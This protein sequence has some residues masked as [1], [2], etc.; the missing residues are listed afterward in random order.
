M[1][2]ARSLQ[3]TTSLP[4]PRASL[5][6]WCSAL[7]AIALCAASARAQVA[8]APPP[9]PAAPT[10]PVSGSGGR[11]RT[12]V[13]VGSAETPYRITGRVINPLTRSPVARAEVTASPMGARR[14]G[15]FAGRAGGQAASA[16]TDGTGRFAVEVPSAGGWSLNVSAHGY[17]SQA[18]DEHE[19]FSTAIILTEASP[20]HEVTFSLTPA[21]S[22]EGYVMD[23]AGEAVRDAQLTLSVVPAAS[24]EEQHPRPQTR[25]SQRTDDRGYFKFFGLLAGRYFVRV[26]AQPWYATNAGRF[27]FGGGIGVVAGG[28]SGVGSGFRSVGAIGGANGPSPDPLDVVYPVV[29]YPGVT[30]YS[31]AV[32]IALRGGET[33]EADF[34]LSPMPGFHLHLAA[35][36]AAG[37]PDADGRP[38]G[39]SGP[40]AYLSLV[41]PD[42]TETPVP[43]PMLRET[44]GE[45]EFS[46]LVPG[47]Y[48][49]HHQG[50]SGWPTGTAKV[51]IDENSARTVEASEASPGV[52]VTVKIDAEADRP[53]LQVSFRDVESGQVNFMRGPQSLPRRTR[54]MTGAEG[55][56][57]T[58]RDLPDR[59]I[60]LQPGRYDLVLGGIGDLHLASIEAKGA[61]AAGRRVTITGGE[62]VLTLHVS[63]G[64]ANVTGF[65]KSHGAPLEGAMVLLVPATLGD[66]AGLNV[67]RRDQS[68]SDGSFDITGVLPGAYILAAIDHGW[69]VNWSDPATLRRFLM[70][71]LPLDL[72]A[73]GDRKETVEAQSP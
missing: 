32:P 28:V 69:D 39:V 58:E 4:R 16:V 25:G 33:R 5:P 11:E 35:G 12:A 42:G 24:P 64:R 3:S 37:L 38:A 23:E 46:G 30:D 14:A 57:A 53:S 2:R 67:T 17:R 49:V 15:R 63:S 31:Q 6:V 13:Q 47:S 61:A 71:G 66:P 40:N 20:T 60:S 1:T 7:C 34:R 29:W 72:T 36:G 54:V 43:T 51:R 19:G 56:P 48:V 62:P 55:A 45:A 73:A 44:N 9:P 50:E 22:I 21:A 18:Y 52:M 26:Q 59:T 65:V 27:G 70:N 68:N 8:G 41:L 10:L